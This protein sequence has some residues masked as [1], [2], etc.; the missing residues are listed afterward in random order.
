MLLGSK[1]GCGTVFELSPPTKKGDAWTETVLY[2]FP[3]AKQGYLPWGDLVFDSAGKLYGATEFGGGYGTNCGDAFYQYCGAV[4]ELSPPNTKGGKWQ[5]KT[6]YGFKGGDDGANPNGGLVLHGSGNIYGTTYIG[7]YNCPHH[8]GQGC[9]TV[10]QLKP[11][12]KKGGP[13]AEEQLHVFK[14][15]RDGANPAGDL[16]VDVKGSLYGTAQGGNPS[17]G[18]IAFQLGATN[19]GRW[20]ETVLRWFS[21]N[22]P[23]AFTA[24]LI[25]DSSGNLY[26]P[27]DDGAQFRGTVIRLKRPAIPDNNWVPAILYTFQGSPDGAGPAARLIFNAG[28]LYGTTQAGGAAQTCQGGCGTVYELAP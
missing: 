3:T 7:G 16:I 24:G 25:F 11:P 12:T 18:G 27:T 4:F 10:F 8:S 9:G 6:L 2:S 19:D 14:S 23:G 17:G 22:G 28:N 21:N 15:G 26:G 13:W 5:E 1:L 20:K